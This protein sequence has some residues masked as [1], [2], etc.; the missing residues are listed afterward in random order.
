MGPDS[1]PRNV[2]STTVG[3]GPMYKINPVKGDEWSCNDVH[4]LTLVH[5]ETGKIKDV[6]LN[7][8][9]QWSKTQKH[10]WKQFSVGVDFPE[11]Q[12]LTVDP[13]FLGVW[14]GDGTKSLKGVSVSK[15]DAAIV[16]IMEKM[17]HD[18]D[19]KLYPDRTKSCTTWHLFTERGTTNPLL[20]AMREYMQN[21]QVSKEILTS[22]REERLEFL[23]GCLD[24]DGHL[25]HNVYDFVQKN[26]EYM[27]A[28]KF[29][30]RSLGFKVVAGKDKEV[31]GE[32]YQRCFISGKTHLIPCRIPRKKATERTQIKDALRTGFKVSEPEQGEYAGFTLDGDGRFLLGDFTVTHNTELAKALASFLFEDEANLIRFDMSEFMEKHTVARLIGAPPGYKGAEEGGQLTEAVKNKP[33]SVVLFDE[34]EKGHPDVFNLLLQILDDGRLTD[35]QGTLVDFKNTVIIM[36]SNVGSQFLLESTIEHGHVVEEAKESAMEDMKKHFRPEFLGRIDE[37]V[38]FHGLTRRDIDTI[39]DIHIKKIEGLVA[40]K[41]LK[42]NLSAA[43]KEYVINLG[44]QPAYGARPLRRALQRYL[45]D[46]LSLEILK[47][48][49]VVGDTI[50]V[51][52]VNNDLTFEKSSST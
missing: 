14:L 13:Y 10:L 20:N 35:S 44:F 51:D 46:P 32:I 42:L 40:H 28:V 6:P 8:Y 39:A 5:T 4:I 49:F 45:Q 36:T 52:M 7:E 2:L 37:I 25:I 31:D 38:F 34:V 48:R 9:L 43:A 29:V 27:A 19:L 17:A 47:D 15:D 30:A 3:Q 1:L 18:W 22:S 50:Y 16:A 24:S 21:K 23:A 12:K 41:K 11:R 26:K 33:Y